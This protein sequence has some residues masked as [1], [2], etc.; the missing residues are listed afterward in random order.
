MF[1]RCRY[2][3]PLMMFL[4]Y[5]H[6]SSSGSL[7]ALHQVLLRACNN[8]VEQLSLLNVLHNEEQVLRRFDYLR[9]NRGYFVQLDD[10]RM[11]NELEDVYF[12]GNSLDIGNIHDSLLLKDLYGHTFLSECVCSHFDLSE[13]TL[14][15]GLADNVVADLTRLGRCSY[16][17][18]GL[19]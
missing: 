4:K 19:C 11:P 18:I 2:A 17:Y 14:S 6:A 1:R 15:D 12:T 8:V 10:V 7:A 16:L 9:S 5:L 3:I 13:G